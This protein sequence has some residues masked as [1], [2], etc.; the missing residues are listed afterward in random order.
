MGRNVR[1]SSPRS[2]D[3]KGVT[4]RGSARRK[5][6]SSGRR[7]KSL[8]TGRLIGLFFFF[9]LAFA[10]MGARLFVLQV[11]EAPAYAKIAAKQR[12]RTVDFPAR[13]GAIFDRS[14]QA[15]ALSVDLQTI[16]ADP[17]N[18]ANAK[19]EAAKLSPVLGMGRSDLVRKLSASNQFQYLARKVPP[20]VSRAVKKLN[21]AGIYLQREPRRFYPGGRLAS[22]VL[23]FAGVDG[24]GLA[25]T[26]HQYN[27]IL[28]GTPG[29]LTLE[30]DP[31]GRPLP[32]ATF[33]YSPPRQ[34]TS[35]F[36]TLDKTLQYFTELTLKRALSQYHAIRGTAIVMRPATGQIL[37]MANAPD[38]NPNRPQDSPT[39][40]QRNLAVSDV[41]EPGSAYKLVTASGA[42][43]EKVVTPRTTFSVP[44]SIA[45]SDRV[46]H[47]AEIHSTET[48]TVKQIIEQSS[49]VG[50]IEMGLRLGARK[51]YEYE[52]KFGFGSPTGLDFPGESGGIVTPVKDWTGPTIATVPIGQGVAVTPMQL[53]TA[54]ASIANGGVWVQ[55]KLLY[56]T[57]GGNGKVER[58]PPPDTRRILS[59]RT[60]AEMTNIFAGVVKRGTGV[61]AQIPGYEVAGKTG[62][63]QEPLPTGGYGN[64]Y[65]ATFVGFAPA[66]HPSLAVLVTL[67][68]PT[69]I[70]GGASAAPTFKTI[71]QFALRREGVPPT[72]NAAK[73]ARAIAASQSGNAPGHD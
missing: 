26:E 63:A 15:L 44:E 23:G 17:L 69:P 60:A 65:R 28:T 21:L 34:G 52:R 38:F 35:L 59:R 5:A 51:L 19:K 29:H 46:F 53:L 2:W 10:A 72:G 39:A 50:T 4:S 36:L 12:V 9:V 64:R 27:G 62:T 73:A 13:R 70:W 30:Q 6:P 25:G 68:D 71:M 61:A 43:E 24:T 3:N 37:A 66:Q 58:T 42:L 11:L 14:G 48:L 56:A 1:R 55:P 67:D 41:Y 57:M 20:K 47:D 54:Y 8:S 31:A 7:P 22:Q 32:Q 33:H 16:Y 18:V 49:N 45:V 40:L